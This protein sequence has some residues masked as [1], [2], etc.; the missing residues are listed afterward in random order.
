M[1]DFAKK[2]IKNIPYLV[3][4]GTAG[5]GKTTC[6]SYLTELY[7]NFAVCSF[8]GKAANVLRRK[9]VEHAATIHSTIYDCEED[10]KGKLRFKLKK[11]HKVDFTGLFV[12]EASMI[13][14][15]LFEDLMSFG[16]PIIFFG[17]HAQLE[18]VGSKFNLMEKPHFRLETIHR[19]ANN[20]AKFADF[21][22]QGHAASNYEH[23]DEQVQLSKKNKMIEEEFVKYDQIICGFNKTRL[24]INNKMRSHFNYSETLNKHEKIICLKNNR[25][26]KVFNGMQGNVLR[27]DKKEILFEADG[28][29]RKIDIDIRQF[30]REKLIEDAN[31][32]HE[33]AYFDYAY[34]ITAHKAQGD[35]FDSVCV[36]EEQAPK[37]W[38]PARWSYT[39]ATRAKQKLL[40]CL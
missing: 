27:I 6:L 32:N 2:E 16:L 20:I 36:F 29:K 12:D 40:W 18:P 37:L 25:N 38:N 21:L 10:S 31:N 5:S 4:S 9:G 1:I 8:T 7:P 34:A 17:D 35:E 22:R 14:K 33:L 39:A 28:F 11:P 3:L 23:F 19:N 26:L 30:G 13:S 15:E 24:I